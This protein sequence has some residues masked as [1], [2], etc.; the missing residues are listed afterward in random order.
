[1]AASLSAPFM[2][3]VHEADRVAEML[4]QRRRSAPRRRRDRSPR[5]RRPAGRPSRPARRRSSARPTAATTSSM[6]SSGTRARVD[7]LAAG[8][9]LAQLRDVHVAEIGRAPACAGSASRSSPA[10][11]RPR[12]CGRA[13]GA[14]ARRSG[15]ARRRPQAPRSRNSTS[16]WNSACVPTSRSS[17]P[18]AS[19]ARMSARS[20]AALAAG[21]DRDAQAGGL[22]ERRDASRDAG[23]R[24]FR[25]A[26]SGRPAGRPRPTVAAASSATTVLPEPTSPCSRRSMRSGLREVGVDLRD[27]ARLRRRERIGQGARRSSARSCP[28]PLLGRPA[29]RFWLARTSASASWPAS[30]SS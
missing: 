13:R 19:R 25:S 16:S 5:T 18:A 22:G 2:L 29:R 1:M 7:R 17:S 27:G 20:R 8:R 14:G 23:A 9:L 11:P 28:S 15:A 3:A 21:E 4:L 10:R 6:R 12:P 26:P 30:N 24:E